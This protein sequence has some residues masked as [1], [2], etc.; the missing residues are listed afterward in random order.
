MLQARRQADAIARGGWPVEL[1][2]EP[3]KPNVWHEIKDKSFYDIPLRSLK[4]K[5]VGNLWAAGRII[6][7]DPLAFASAR[8]M[9]TAFATGQA[10]GVA[11]ALHGQ[12]DASDYQ[13]V[14]S[15]L[16]RQEA[17]L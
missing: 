15:E 6:D 10:A 3:G 12:Q 13:S 5:G 17:I 1:H 2:P 11:A 4:V 16:L 9:G 14:R 8:V 7:C